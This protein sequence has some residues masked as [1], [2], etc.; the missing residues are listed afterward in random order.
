MNIAQLFDKLTVIPNIEIV[1]TL[2]PEVFLFADQPARDALLERLDRVG[3]CG[4]L[5]LAQQQVNVLGHDHIGEDAQFV[6]TPDSFKG[7]HDD[8]LR[9]G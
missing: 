4:T 3:E 2:L 9:L 1:I 6:S 7:G 5:R 8:V